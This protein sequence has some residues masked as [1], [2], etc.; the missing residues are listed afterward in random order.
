MC[1]R[2]SFITS[3]LNRCGNL[4]H[5]VQ[6]LSKCITAERKKKSII[7]LLLQLLIYIQNEKIQFCF[8]CEM[9]LYII[10]Y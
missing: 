10:V 4:N 8:I 9:F 3:D 5:G 2:D 6:L 1:R 7:L